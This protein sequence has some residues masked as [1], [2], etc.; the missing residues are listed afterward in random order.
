MAVI[1]QGGYQSRATGF[2]CHILPPIFSQV[3]P[4]MWNQPAILCLVIVAGQTIQLV[5]RHEKP[6]IRHIQ[7]GE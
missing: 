1:I 6:C 5:P 7:W 3:V 4:Y 2:K